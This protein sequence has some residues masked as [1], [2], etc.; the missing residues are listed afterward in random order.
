MH[1]ASKQTFFNQRFAKWRIWRIWIRHLVTCTHS[2][3][4]KSG[5][6]F[7]LKLLEVRGSTE[8]HIILEGHGTKWSKQKLYCLNPHIFWSSKDH[9]DPCKPFEVKLVLFISFRHFKPLEVSQR[10]LSKWYKKKANQRPL[11]KTD[12]W[13]NY[14]NS[15]L[16]LITSSVH[17]DY[18]RKLHLVA[19]YFSLFCYLLCRYHFWA[20]WTN[21]NWALH[22]LAH[23]GTLCQKQ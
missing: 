15:D 5:G 12:N 4:L 20:L 21:T 1:I 14:V 11:I 19:L 17:S 2:S 7:W 23:F 3:L 13:I 16:S 18:L 6:L 22:I 8:F 10:E 9:P